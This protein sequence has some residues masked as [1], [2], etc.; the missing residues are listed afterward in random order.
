MKEEIKAIVVVGEHRGSPKTYEKKE[1]LKE[2]G[3]IW[4]KYAEEWIF[5]PGDDNKTASIIKWVEEQ[6]FS[7]YLQFY[8]AH[9]EPRYGNFVPRWVTKRFGIEYYASAVDFS[10]EVAEE[11]KIQFPES[12]KVFLKD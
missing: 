6:G 9:E 10:D 11:L 1:L 5:I 3:G 8:V 2:K 7:A 4:N 12:I